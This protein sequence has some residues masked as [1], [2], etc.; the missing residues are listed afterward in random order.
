MKTL[1]RMIDS[2][3]GRSSRKDRRDEE[4]FCTETSCRVDKVIRRKIS[5]KIPSRDNC[6]NSSNCNLPK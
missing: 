2:I 5:T 6:F 3:K 4:I 1:R